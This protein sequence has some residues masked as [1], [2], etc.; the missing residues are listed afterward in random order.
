[1]WGSGDPPNVGLRE[2]SENRRDPRGKRVQDFGG[3]E[4]PGVR[5]SCSAPAP[6]NPLLGAFSFPVAGT[7]EGKRQ[8]TATSIHLESSLLGRESGGGNVSRSGAKA[9]GDL[10]VVDCAGA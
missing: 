3:A 5:A 7:G 1:M 10:P 6:K 8:G 9:G 2:G 4:Q